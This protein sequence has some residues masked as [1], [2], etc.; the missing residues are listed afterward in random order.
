[1]QSADMKSWPVDLPGAKNESE[2]LKT[3][4]SMTVCLA[5]SQGYMI[6]VLW[7]LIRGAVTTYL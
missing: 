5:S 1:M 7:V 6:F 2:K 4:I 3:N